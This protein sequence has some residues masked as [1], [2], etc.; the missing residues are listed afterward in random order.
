MAI[1]MIVNLNRKT[2]E[3]IK[4]LVSAVPHP[5]LRFLEPRVLD[6]MTDKYLDDPL[7][8]CE[9]GQGAARG[10]HLFAS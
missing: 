4:N 1:L 9:G 2:K 3:L 8:S 7:L 6:S 5:W 10:S